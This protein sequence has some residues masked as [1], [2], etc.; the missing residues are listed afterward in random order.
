MRRLELRHEAESEVQAVA[1]HYENER[2]GLGLRFESEL[3]ATFARMAE[4]PLLFAEID[5]GVR[6]ALLHIFPYG[7]FFTVEQELVLVIAVLHLHRHPSSWKG[8]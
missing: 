7:V 1:L 6:R 5:P 8:R 4:G 2:P 3:S